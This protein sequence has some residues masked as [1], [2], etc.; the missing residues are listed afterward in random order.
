VI[1]LAHVGGVP[2]EEFLPAIAGSGAG[3][4]AARAWL[5]LQLRRDR[6]RRPR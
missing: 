3:L 5:N 6:R 4:L 1:P 2:L